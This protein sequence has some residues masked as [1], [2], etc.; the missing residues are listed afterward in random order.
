MDLDNYL[1][2]LIHSSIKKDFI[3]KRLINELKN[4]NFDLFSLFIEGD[5][6]NN[7]KL[8]IKDKKY[9]VNNNYIFIL[10][11]YYP[12]S[13]P[14]I[15]INSR[16]YKSFLK[17]STIQTLNALK[18]FKGY[19]CLCCNSYSCSLW[20]P[21]YTIL[22]IVSEIKEYREIRES[23]LYKLMCDKISYKYLN[24]DIKLEDWIY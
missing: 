16:L 1:I 18:L 10:D 5:G 9:H 15:K 21:S 2:P 23:I 17:I 11:K 19:D 6:E 8:I 14:I 13:R 22:N 4:I 24:K 12:F 3:K 20:A 7:I